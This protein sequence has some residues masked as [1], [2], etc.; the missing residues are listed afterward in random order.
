[1]NERDLIDEYADLI[2]EK[3]RQDFIDDVEE[4]GQLF[5]GTVSQIESPIERRLCVALLAVKTLKSLPLVDI[6]DFPPNCL[7]AYVTGI[8]VEPQFQIG[9]YRIDFKI[10]NKNYIEVGTGE[11]CKR[12]AEHNKTVL[13]ECDSQEWHERT[14]EERRYEKAR[15]RYLIKCGFAVFHYTGKEILE[16]PFKIAK[17]IFMFLGCF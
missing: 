9:E 10:S 1:M 13:V 17:E 8:Q 16:N 12:I 11:S 7:A 15:D 2:A 5:E 14:E 6:Y 4:D 3:A